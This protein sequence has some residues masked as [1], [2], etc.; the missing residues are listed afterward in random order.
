MSTNPK[1]GENGLV[2]ITDG[3][4]Y[5]LTEI[6]KP[7]GTGDVSSALALRTGMTVIGDADT[8]DGKA[9]AS[10]ARNAKIPLFLFPPYTR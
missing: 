10:S 4:A 8:T 3:S 1:N 5:A 9:N 6:V 7:S 2:T